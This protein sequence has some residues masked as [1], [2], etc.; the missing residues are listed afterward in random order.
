MQAS[1]AWLLYKSNTLDEGFL[2]ASLRGFSVIDD[3][4][5]TEEEFR[6]AMGISEDI[7]YGPLPFMAD[8][9]NQKM[10]Y[11]DVREE[12][13]VKPFPTMLILDAKFGQFS[14]SMSVCVQRPQLLV[15]LDFMF[16]VVEFFVPTVGS[17][18]SD[19]EDKRTMHVLDA[20]IL[21]QSTYRQPSAEI[22][23]SPQRPLIVDNERFDHFIYDGNGGI[24]CLK[25]RQGA[26]LS[27]PSVEAM[28]F[29][30]SGKRLQ[31]KNVIIKVNFLTIFVHIQDK[32]ILQRN[33]LSYCLFRCRMG[34]I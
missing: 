7:G 19:E 32:N 13:N 6:L 29:V 33:L 28:I 2:S 1:E 10:V 27:A 20:I 3:R 9:D 30:G 12:N 23:L 31:F 5:G 22:S 15:A 16:A 26:D 21:D 25:D 11:S 8:N 14:T 18:L 34:I 17:M 24:L 4:E